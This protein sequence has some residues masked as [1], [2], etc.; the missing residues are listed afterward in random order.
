MLVHQKIR[1]DA[2]IALMV[3]IPRVTG[4]PL[5]LFSGHRWVTILGRFILAL[6][7]GWFCVLVAIE[8][9]SCG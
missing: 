7:S 3:G 5:I 9:A 1:P 4:L 2:A 6:A 8:V